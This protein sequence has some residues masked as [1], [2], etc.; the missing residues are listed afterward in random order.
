MEDRES[1]EKEEDVDGEGEGEEEVVD[2][3]EDELGEEGGMEVVE[4]VVAYSITSVASSR[5]RP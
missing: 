1:D 3:D 4:D 2:E 5:I